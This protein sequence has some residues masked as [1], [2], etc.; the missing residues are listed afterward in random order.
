M[1]VFKIIK[2]YI[3]TVIDS[4]VVFVGLWCSGLATFHETSASIAV[5]QLRRLRFYLTVRYRDWT[6][7]WGV[8]WYLEGPY[9]NIQKFIIT[10]IPSLAKLSNFKI[11]T[12]CSWVVGSL[13]R[14]HSIILL[15]G[16]RKLDCDSVA[17]SILHVRGSITSSWRNAVVLWLGIGG[18]RSWGTVGSSRFIV[19]LRLHWLIRHG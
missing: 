10:L 14:L 2:L 7:H 12:W 18:T 1:V 5:F 4:G 9:G 16:C 3:K 8:R 11:F 19:S 15:W 17:S 6:L 13:W